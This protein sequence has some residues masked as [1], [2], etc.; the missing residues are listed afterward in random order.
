MK[1]RRENIRPLDNLTGTIEDGFN[2]PNKQKRKIN[3]D[4]GKLKVDINIDWNV[5]GGLKGHVMKLKEMIL[6]PL[7]YPEEFDN[8]KIQP[9]R[10]V[11]FHGPPGTGKTLVARV[12]AAEASKQGKKISFYMRKGADVL[13]K[14]VGEAERQLP[15]LFSEAHKNQPSIIFFDEIDGLA[16]VRSSRQDQIHSSIVSTLLALM[17]GLDKRGQIVIIGATNRIDSIDPALRRPGRFDR[18]LAFNLPSRGARKQIFEIHTKDWKPKP[19]VKI[20]ESLASRSAGFC[21]AT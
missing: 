19:N 16:P 21:G 1:K 4:V 6:L 13:S 5:V 12:L 8:F 18:E 10:G 20:I 3:A 2:K 17:D 14:W 9:P 15:L 7:L 11:L